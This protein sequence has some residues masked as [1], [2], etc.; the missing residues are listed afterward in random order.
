MTSYVSSA[1]ENSRSHYFYIVWTT[2]NK[3]RICWTI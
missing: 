3:I 2:D 1:N